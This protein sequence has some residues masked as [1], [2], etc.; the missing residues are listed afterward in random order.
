MTGGIS[1][2]YNGT[3]DLAM[4]DF[5]D[6]SRYGIGVASSVTI[7]Y[8]VRVDMAGA[9]SP[10]YSNQAI[11]TTA[12]VGPNDGITATFDKQDFS[13]PDQSRSRWR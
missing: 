2:S 1:P 6:R 10:A 9:T 13:D 7:R 11:V 12:I 3:S 8:T 4:S 5:H